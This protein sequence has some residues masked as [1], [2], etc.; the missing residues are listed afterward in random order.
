VRREFTEELLH[1]SGIHITM[2][3][4]HTMEEGKHQGVE[5]AAKS[6]VKSNLASS[7]YSNGISCSFNL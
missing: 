5:A 3:Y 6:R 4:V 2:G 7:Y 1:Y